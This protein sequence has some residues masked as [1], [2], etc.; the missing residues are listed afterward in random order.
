MI[1]ALTESD[2]ASWLRLWDA[3]CVF[4]HQDIPAHVTETTWARIMDAASTMNGL[5]AID[6]GGSVVGFAIYF[7]H[8]KTWSARDICYLEDLYVD[9]SGRGRGYGRALIEA[10]VEVAR[11][12]G[13][14]AVYWHTDTGNET[15]RALYD[16]LTP[17]GDKV[18][19]EIELE[20]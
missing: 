7:C 16:K 9:E 2:K 4:Y 3:Y 15:A 5:A 14:C 13:W 12:E 17:V 11:T 18:R 1:R 6:D 20:D 19:Y 8:P 10:V